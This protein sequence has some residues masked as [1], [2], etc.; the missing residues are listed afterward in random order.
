MKKVYESPEMLR[1]AYASED[2]LADTLSF[3]DVEADGD[4]LP[5]VDN[6]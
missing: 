6:E 4:Q 5:G 2:V 3:G 1:L